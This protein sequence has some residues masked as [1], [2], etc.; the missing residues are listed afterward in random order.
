MMSSSVGTRGNPRGGGGREKSA[1][2]N[3]Q[4]QHHQSKSSTGGGS[5]DHTPHVG[6]KVSVFAS[7]VFRV[8]VTQVF[9]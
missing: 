3:Q 1:K 6:K 9:H 5:S 7:K 8:T 2:A 4:N